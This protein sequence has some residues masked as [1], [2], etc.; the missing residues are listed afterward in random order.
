MKN[1]GFDEFYVDAM[2]NYKQY[3]ED[4]IEN[5]EV[6]IFDYLSDNDCLDDYE[7]STY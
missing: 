3:S 2:K 5:K 4:E 7:D 6:A 1:K